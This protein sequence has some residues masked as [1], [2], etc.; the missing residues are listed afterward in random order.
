[1]IEAIARDWESRVA[2]A[3]VRKTNKRIGLDT[4]TRMEMYAHLGDRGEPANPEV[5][6]RKVDP[7]EYLKRLIS[8]LE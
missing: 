4:A 7:I 2:W 6:P 3:V 1:M 5:K 8:K